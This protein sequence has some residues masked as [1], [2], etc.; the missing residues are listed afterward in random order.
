MP[1]TIQLPVAVEQRLRNQSSD[2]EA[3]VKEA[4]LLELFRRGKLT[5]FELSESLGLDR[6]ETDAY[7]KSRHVF[8]G[9]LT[10]HDLEEQTETLNRLLGPIPR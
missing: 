3:E 10:M 9:S 6:F 2:L 4:A 8:E 1:V 7:L 5:H